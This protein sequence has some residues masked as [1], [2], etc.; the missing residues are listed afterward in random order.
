MEF[1]LNA[2]FSTGCAWH[3]QVQD[4]NITIL[5]MGICILLFC[6]WINLAGT[7]SGI[8]AVCESQWPTSN[9]VCGDTESSGYGFSGTYTQAD[10]AKSKDDCLTWCGQQGAGCCELRQYTCLHKPNGIVRYSKE[11]YVAT[12]VMCKSNGIIYFFLSS[13]FSIKFPLLFF[14]NQ[15][16]LLFF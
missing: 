4:I 14:L 15:D 11:H 3:G 8:K 5:F 2:T 7:T 1:F 13:P 16:S 12:A 10:S 9:F 6:L